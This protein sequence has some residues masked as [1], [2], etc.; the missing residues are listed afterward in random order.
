MERR[1][2]KA[3]HKIQ[4]GQTTSQVVRRLKALKRRPAGQ[5]RVDRMFLFGSRARG[6]WLLT[7]DADVMKEGRR[8]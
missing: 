4:G 8:I 1:C 5:I 7:S 6:D 3:A 2:A